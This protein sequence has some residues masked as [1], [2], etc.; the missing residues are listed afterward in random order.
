MR[1]T[2]VAGDNKMENQP[3]NFYTNAVSVAISIFDLTIA[4]R[5][6]SP[7]I[8]Q[9]G[10]MLVLNGQPTINVCDELTVRMSPQ[11]AKALAV[12]LVK[13]IIEYEKQFDVKLPLEPELTKLWAEV[14]K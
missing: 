1:S 6:Q 12:L 10:N 13:N 11:H 14:I 9:S 7:Q 3:V 4:M 5:S 2:K 8:D